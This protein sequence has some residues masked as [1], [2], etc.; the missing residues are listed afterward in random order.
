MF[1][2]FSTIAVLSLRDVSPLNCFLASSS[3]LSKKN[4]SEWQFFPSLRA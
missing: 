2:T 3:S 4:I 1:K